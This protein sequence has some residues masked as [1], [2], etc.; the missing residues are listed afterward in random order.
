[1]CGR[2]AATADPAELVAHFHVDVAP[3]RELA[4][5]YNV[6]PST[7][8]YAVVDRQQDDQ[9]SRAL[10]TL[11]WGLIPSWAKDPAI[12]N[13]MINARLETAATKPSFRSAWRKRR[14]LLPARGYYEWQAPT[15]D[16][17][18]RKQ[19]FFFEDPKNPILAMAALFEWWRDPAIEAD[20]PDA[21]VGSTTILTTEATGV[22][23]QVHHRMP[24]LV[25][26][27]NWDAWLDPGFPGDPASLLD[28]DL[29]AAR[30]VAYP[31]STA[32]NAVGHNGP[33]LVEPV[34]PELRPA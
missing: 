4:P 29:T 12:G 34:G 15:G 26:A 19:P 14:A 25:E 22:A 32:V 16:A 21:W 31:V 11:R 8:V 28:P 30:L 20:D 18:G 17:R 27:G 2:Y 24:V 5:N 3:Q 33:D 23:A 7:Q 13:R 10:E 6:A 1:M 9:V